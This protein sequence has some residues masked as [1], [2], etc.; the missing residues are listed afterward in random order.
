M[1]PGGEQ[2]GGPHGPARAQPAARAPGCSAEVTAPAAI[3]AGLRWEGTL[4]RESALRLCYL[5]AAAQATGLLQLASDRGRFALYL[6]RGAVEHASSTAPEDDLG[7]YLVARGVVNAEAVADAGRVKDSLGGDLVAA[8][9]H[10]RLLD[11]ATSFRTLQEHGAQVVARALAVR[12]GAARWDPAA[13]APG[14]AFPLGSRWGLLCDAARRLDGLAVRGLLGERLR[15]IA[16][17]GRGRIDANELKLTAVEARVAA[18]FDGRRSP[19]QVAAA[20]PA[21]AEVILRVALLLGETELL[22]F[23]EV[24]QAPPPSAS[25]APAKVASRPTADPA[26]SE[27][28]PRTRSAI[29]PEPRVPPAG[30]VPP[31]PS[32][33]AVPPVPRASPTPAAPPVPPIRGPAPRPTSPRAPAPPSAA[34]SPPAVDL[35]GLRA[36]H[37]KLGTADHFE[38]L[39]VAREAAPAQLKAAYFGLARRYHPDAGPATE[40][41]EVKA[42]RADIFA[43]IGEAW[44]VLSD[45]GRRVAY[46]KELSAGGKPEV[47]V[48][49]IFRS[50]ELFQRAT[51]LV[52]TRQYE[53]AL[54]HLEEAIQLNDEPE[55]AVWK[56]WAEF[57]AA[58]EPARQHAQ[59]AAAI[60]AALKKVPRCLAGYLFLG[61]MAKMAGQLDLAERHL[62]RGLALEPEHAEL[63]RELKFLRK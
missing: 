9:A 4:E 42:L 2:G 51:V 17:R 24:V 59:S 29:P 43:R 12:D 3:A 45:D 36:F 23:G 18:L 1:F 41:G 35:L 21:D 39:G 46:L 49:G 52:R 30:P 13:P 63:A 47:D 19:G 31:I 44:G 62:R 22:E 53:R 20:Y 7:R 54:A 55:F 57:L 38:T 5:A 50:E 48:S 58:P 32:I 14:S 37:G 34:P 60:E 10:L 27:Q 28:A 33:P 15:R 40:S 25:A 26:A 61:Q 56:A 6:R 16:S 8:L 11:P